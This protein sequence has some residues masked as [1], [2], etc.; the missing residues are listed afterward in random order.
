LNDRGASFGQPI[1]VGPCYR[2]VEIFIPMKKKLLEF[3]NLKISFKAVW[4]LNEGG[5]ISSGEHC[6]ISDH[7]IVKKKF[8]LDHHGRWNPIGE[9]Q[10]DRVNHYLKIQFLRIYFF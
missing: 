9:W 4:R 1:G 7:D 8:C 6:F 2:Q 3:I 10:W 5:E